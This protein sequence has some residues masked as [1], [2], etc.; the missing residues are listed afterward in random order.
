LDVI[1]GLQ[2]RIDKL[3]ADLNSQ[4]AVLAEVTAQQNELRGSQQMAPFDSGSFDEKEKALLERKQNAAKEAEGRTADLDAKIADLEQQIQE[5]NKLLLD[6]D[7]AARQEQR[8]AEL[9]AEEKK[10]G[11]E[12]ENL[13]QGLYLCDEFVRAKVGMIDQRINGMFRTIRFKLFEEQ[14]NGGLKECCE[15]LIPSDAGALVP[16]PSSN[17]SAI[18]NAGLE[19][20]QALAGYYGTEL[21]VI[22]DNAERVTHPLPIHQQVIRLAVSEADKVLRLEVAS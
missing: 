8:V 7:L 3:Q 10:L 18:V 11:E 13:E 1:R 17:D 6:L 19:C 14:M 15:A 20:I 4:S 12:Y 21:P 5:K 16:Y 22:L 9:E 2:D